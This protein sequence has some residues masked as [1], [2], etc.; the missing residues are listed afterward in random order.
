MREISFKQQTQKDS[1]E[2]DPIDENI[3]TVAELHK[4]AENKVSTPQRTI[5]DMTDFLGRPRKSVMS[6]I[7]RCGVL[8][9]F[10]ACLC[11]SATVCMFSSIGSASLLSFCVCCLNDISRIRLLTCGLRQDR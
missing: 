9:L 11:S 6:S 2:A 5:E 8:T 3:Q 1:K 4:H 10:S 7:V